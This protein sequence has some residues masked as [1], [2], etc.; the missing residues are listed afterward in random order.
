M[1]KKKVQLSLEERVN[2]F[3]LLNELMEMFKEK[4]RGDEIKH[5]ELAQLSGFEYNSTEF[6]IVASKLKKRFLEERGIKLLAVHGVGYR[7]LTVDE[8]SK[9]TIPERATK[10]LKH[11]KRGK[12][13]LDALGSE[14]LTDHQRRLKAFGIDGFDKQEVAL[15]KLRRDAGVILKY[16][17]LPKPEMK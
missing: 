3:H 13:E 7:L 6:R 9:I 16:E 17:T 4:S 5:E 12:K 1:V 11:V 15:R 10:A 8:Q 14:D 2:Y